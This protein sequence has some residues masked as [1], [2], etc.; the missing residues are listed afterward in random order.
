LFS[1]NAASKGVVE[2]VPEGKDREEAPA[3]ATPKTVFGALFPRADGDAV[4]GA[5]G[6]TAAFFGAREA[7]TLL[8]TRSAATAASASSASRSRCSSRAGEWSLADSL[9]E[10][11]AGEPGSDSYDGIA[12]GGGR[13]SSRASSRLEASRLFASAESTAEDFVSVGVPDNGRSGFPRSDTRGDA[14]VSAAA[15]DGGPKAASFTPSPRSPLGDATRMDARA[16]ADAIASRL[17]RS[18]S[19]ALLRASLSSFASVSRSRLTR[20]DSVSAFLATA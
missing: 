5:T 4:D 9:A 20:R 3:E 13:Y 10:S 15:S 16:L 19:E 12:S 6:E 1:A 14:E 11:A 17:S 2:V 8:E 18:A 7:L